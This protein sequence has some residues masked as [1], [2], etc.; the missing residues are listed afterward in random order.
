MVGTTWPSVDVIGAAPGPTVAVM[1]GVHPNEVAAIDA[2]L[3]LAGD[4]DSTKLRGRVSLL[5]VA[6]RPG[7]IPRTEY[8]VPTDGKNLN[9]SFPGRPDGSF[10]EA[11]AAALLDEWARDAVCLIDLHGGDLRE[12]VAR[13]VVSQLTGDAGFDARQLELARAFGAQFLVRLDA[14]HLARP[15]RS[16][17]GRAGR[18]QH[19]VFA[20]GGS[21]GLL[22]DSDVQFHRDG[23]VGV[24]AHHGMYSAER[25]PP[26]P[27]ELLGYDFLTA[28][29]DG[30]SRSVV[31]AGDRVEAGQPVAVL[32]DGVGRPL[33]KVV[34]PTSGYILWRV[35]HPIV[36]AGDAIVGLGTC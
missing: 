4:L 28:P 35:T 3:R 26:P 17:T 36:A 13:F 9:F 22:V 34:A 5:P 10:T 8:L 32:V 21:H 15:G 6:N 14:A 16:V 12:E 20:E 1:A 19:A 27:L 7:F 18:G 25:S 11:L 23:V 33:A 30:W 24:L 2:V 31:R 29:C